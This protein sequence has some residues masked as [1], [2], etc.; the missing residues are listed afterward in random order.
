MDA[1]KGG[2]RAVTT[3]LA[4]SAVSDGVASLSVSFGSV[5]TV[6]SLGSPLVISPSALV[7]VAF[8]FAHIQKSSLAVLLAN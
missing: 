1:S 8:R 7:R 4:I 3:C 2:C 6:S 5:I